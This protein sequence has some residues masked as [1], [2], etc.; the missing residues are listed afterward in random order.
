MQIEQ[1]YPKHIWS[2]EDCIDMT[3]I[4]LQQQRDKLDDAIAKIEVVRPRQT[5]GE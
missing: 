3:L 4:W 1:H 5:S 2:T